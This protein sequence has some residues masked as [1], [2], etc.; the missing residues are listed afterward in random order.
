MDVQPDD[1][2]G[3]KSPKPAKKKPPAPK[4]VAFPLAPVAS[5]EPYLLR[6]RPYAIVRLQGSKLTTFILHDD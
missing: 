4:P 3:E 2:F 6:P 5:S 1:L